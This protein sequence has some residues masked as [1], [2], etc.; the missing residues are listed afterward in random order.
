[1]SHQ[2]ISG[3]VNKA[4]CDKIQN[5]KYKKYVEKTEMKAAENYAELISNRIP[6]DR[7]NERFQIQMKLYKKLMKR[8]AE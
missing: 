8:K 7:H 1:M 5:K 3:E 4:V 2:E 6:K